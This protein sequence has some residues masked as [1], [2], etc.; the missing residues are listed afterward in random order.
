[1]LTL[2]DLVKLLKQ[3]DY[4]RIPSSDIDWEKTMIRCDNCGN[5]KIKHW[6][7]KACEPKE[8]HANL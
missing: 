4:D 1:M 5:W 8:N 7:C 3:A 2:G 6:R